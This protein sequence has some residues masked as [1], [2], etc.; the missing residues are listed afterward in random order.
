TGWGQTPNTKPKP[1]PEFD[2]REIGTV[3]NAAGGQAQ[4]SAVVEQRRASMALFAASPEEAKLGT[5]IVPN[6]Y[7]LPKLYL[8]DGRSLSAPSTQGAED[9]AKG[10]LRSQSPVFALGSAEVD[11]L[12]L[13]ADDVTDTA[14]FVSFNQT[15]D[16]IDVFNGLIKFTLNKNGEVVQ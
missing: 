15:V 2:V 6:R 4:A 1:L 16:G 3:A 11:S 9:I 13:L 5:R 10:F 14:R 7:G 8:R 12:R